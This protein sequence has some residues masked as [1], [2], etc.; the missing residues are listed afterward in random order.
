MLWIKKMK[1]N[2]LKKI[3][4]FTSILILILVLI[5]CL[6]PVKYDD[7]ISNP[8]LSPSIKYIFGTDYL[9]RDLFI[10]TCYAV[11]NTLF[12]ACF[13]VFCSLFIG[14]VYGTYAGYKGGRIEKNMVMFLNILESIPSFLL[15][16]LF[17]VLLNN[18]FTEKSSILGVLMALIAVSWIYMSRIIINE[19]K[20]I[21]NSDYIRYATIKKASFGHILRFHLLPN[22]KNII[23]IIIIQKIPSIIFIESFL[24]F[25]G[26]G[27][28][29]PF[30][31][32]GKMVSDGLKFFRIYPHE[33][34]VPVISLI[35]IVFLFNIIGEIIIKNKKEYA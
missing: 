32:L 10:R 11:L 3:I 15:I 28:Q 34:L 1:F 22:L 16:I 20:K 21:M 23:I 17:L 27:I 26:I 30:P 31:S 7:I 5:L 24:S 9:G 29:P 2:L 13:S 18:F 25:V 19:T 8:N 6:Y 4:I 12:I 14:V 33:L 35:L